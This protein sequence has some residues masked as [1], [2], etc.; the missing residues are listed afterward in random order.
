M[1]TREAILQ[2]IRNGNYSSKRHLPL[3]TLRSYVIEHFNPIQ[4]KEVDSV[5]KSLCDEGWL[6]DVNGNLKVTELGERMI[7]R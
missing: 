5:I 4:Q 7:Y 3:A 2:L 6:E 1:T